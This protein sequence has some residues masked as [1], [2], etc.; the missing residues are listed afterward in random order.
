MTHGYF[1]R[2]DDTEPNRLQPGVG[3]R[4]HAELA[5]FEGSQ[6]YYFRDGVFAGRFMRFTRE[7][8]R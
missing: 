7:L 5:I 4:A 1:F 8:L 2:L 6:R 3:P